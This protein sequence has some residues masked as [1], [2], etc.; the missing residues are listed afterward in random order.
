MPQSILPAHLS[1]DNFTIGQLAEG[2]IAYVRPEAIVTTASVPNTPVIYKNQPFET[3]PSSNFAVCIY[4]LQGILF[5]DSTTLPDRFSLRRVED[6]R[7]KFVSI[8][9][10]HKIESVL[11]QLRPGQIAFTTP[12]QITAD[13]ADYLWIAVDCPVENIPGGTLRL[14]IRPTPLCVEVEEGS[15]GDY[16]INKNSLNPQR[17]VVPVLLVDKL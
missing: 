7:S 1:A 6:D 12:W 16:K 5:S 4:K 3:S 8:T 9:P 2:Q 14:K 10:V 11:P 17:S 13:E 15:F